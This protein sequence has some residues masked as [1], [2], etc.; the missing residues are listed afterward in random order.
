MGR[1][2]VRP[3]GYARTVSSLAA[4]NDATIFQRDGGKMNISQLLQR[5]SAK[6]PNECQQTDYWFY[7]GE[8][9]FH[10]SDG[11]LF[12]CHDNSPAVFVSVS[13]QAA[14]DWLDGA[15]RRAIETA[16]LYLETNSWGQTRYQVRI[17]DGHTVIAE[18]LL[19]ALLTAYVQWME[20]Q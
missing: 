9:R 19:I 15:V 11:V 7:I 18:S 5:W 6:R 20:G 10:F 14:L 8:Y 13:G 1:R 2:K 3:F 4:G 16:G 17:D 12:A